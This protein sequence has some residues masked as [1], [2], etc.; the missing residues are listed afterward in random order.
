[1]AQEQLEESHHHRARRLG[2]GQGRSASCSIPPSTASSAPT[3]TRPLPIPG[4]R[5]AAACSSST[6]SSTRCRW[7]CSSTTTPIPKARPRASARSRTRSRRGSSDISNLLEID[8]DLHAPPPV[9]FV[10]GP[11][12]FTAI[13]EKL[14]RK[15]THV[16][17]RRHARARHAVGQ[18][19]GIPHAAPPAVSEPRRESAD[20]SKRRVI[21]GTRQPVAAGGARIRRPARVG[22]HRRRQRPRRSA[23]HRA[24]RLAD[25]P[26][27]GEPR[28]N[29]RRSLSSYGD[30]YAP[31]FSCASARDD[32][33]A[34]RAASPSSQ[35]EVD[36]ALGAAGRFSFTVVE[37]LRHRE[38]R[39]LHRARQDRARPA[40]RSAPQV[41]DLHGLRRRAAPCR[42]SSAASSPRSPPASPSRGTPELTVAGYD[43]SFPMTLGKNSRT[44]TKARDSDA[45]HE[46]ASFHNLSAED[47]DDQGEARADRAEPGERLR[48]HQ[49]ARRPQ[50]LRVLRRRQP[51]RCTS[52]KPN[53]KADGVVHAA[54]GRRSAA[55]SSRRRISP[56]QVSQVE[57]Y[58]W[59][60]KTK[61]ADRRQ[62]AAP[63]RSPATTASARAAAS[64]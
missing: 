12:E 39:V 60:P 47:R 32:L 13:I 2:Q 21:V 64:G 53:D 10:W 29:W 8:R 58:G 14:G 40:Q 54:L 35:V 7:S 19:Q 4:P 42:A 22:A 33:I 62:R 46:I 44:W 36:L 3:P 34:R 11:L 56:R 41:D 6:A 61:E 27:H 18:L 30:F 28:W 49:E 24:R 59:N 9:R 17:S 16:P 48:V 51:R 31:A 50:P 5:Q 43:H 45:A 23:R 1:M 52:H 15:V 38:A 57:V 26:A 55:A 63:A 25:R 20:K 37:Y